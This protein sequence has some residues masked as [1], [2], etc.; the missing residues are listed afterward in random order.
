MMQKVSVIIPVYNVALY[1]EECISSVLSQTYS[2]LEIIIVDDCGTDNSMELVEKAI[3]G[4]DRD[5]TVLRHPCNQGLSA[6]R[7][8]GIRHATGEWLYFLDSDDYLTPHC[9]ESL[10]QMAGKYPE[11]EIVYGSAN[12]VSGNTY[13]H[14][15][16]RTDKLYDC[17]NQIKLMVMREM[18][19]GTA[20]N[21]LIKRGWLLEH[22]L[23]FRPGIVHE[24]THWNYFAAKHVTAI[25][26]CKTVTYFYRYNPTGIMASRKQERM[27]SM[28]ILI[29]DFAL[30]IDRRC[31]R[32]QLYHVLYTART[33]YIT[34]YGGEG[35]PALVRYFLAGIYLL[36]ILL[37]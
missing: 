6:A 2:E 12:M 1:V 34:R 27:D 8:T 21:K 35:R 4:S 37:K 16:C 10:M 23:F 31:V 15:Y 3:A 30:H 18:L 29:K 19:P 33:L 14:L 32:E 11:A 5:I 22:R 13:E 9:V 26:T 7:N 20:W 17:R 24:D 25:A 28:E 36:K